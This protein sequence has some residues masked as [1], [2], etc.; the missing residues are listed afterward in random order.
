[1]RQW[2]SL[3]LELF[4]VRS[5][6]GPLPMTV[7]DFRKRTCFP[8]LDTRTTT[9]SAGLSAGGG[10]VGFSAAGRLGGGGLGVG[11]GVTRSISG[12]DFST[13]FGVCR[14]SIPLD[15]FSSSSN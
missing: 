4:K 10:T 8:V 13:L 9:G 15:D 7:V 12:S 14:R 6:P 2:R 5:H 11:A 3:T 1:M